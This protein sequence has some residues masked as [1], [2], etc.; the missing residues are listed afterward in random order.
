MA[1]PPV[2]YYL[3]I[4]GTE[5]QDAATFGA[6]LEG[7]G[8]KNLATT[9]LKPAKDDANR[10]FDPV[11]TELPIPLVEAR[12]KKIAVVAPGGRDGKGLD[13]FWLGLGQ[14]RENGQV[15]DG[16]K[17]AANLSATFM[18][19]LILRPAIHTHELQPDVLYR[20]LADEQLPYPSPHAPAARILYV[21]SH[22]YQ[23]G[24]MIGERLRDPAEPDVKDYDPP[25][26][27]G[28]VQV[29]DHGQGFHGPEWIVLAQCSTLNSTIWSL[30]ARVLAAS[31]PGVRGILAYEEASPKSDPAIRIAE[32]FFGYL[33]RGTPFLDAWAEANR[34]MKWSALV[35][36]EARR[37]TLAN[38]SRWQQL[39]DVSTSK[40]KASYHGYGPAL[41]AAGEPVYDTLPPFW[42]RLERQSGPGVPFQEVVPERYTDAT[43]RF[44]EGANY[45]WTVHGRDIGTIREARITVVHLRDSLRENQPPWNKLFREYLPVRGVNVEGFGTTTVV[46]RPDSTVNLPSI[47]WQC[48]A[49]RGD[50]AGLE[51]HSFLWFRVA[52]RTDGG[53]L[54]HDF[55]SLGLY[56]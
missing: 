38:I 22:G 31:S 42:L 39:S 1:G 30:W 52:I 47:E 56:Y 2:L 24:V 4:D 37:D 3:A 18:R 44:S 23:S 17:L 40:T 10:L 32:R 16:R 6:L 11:H 49:N 53:P 7:R 54:Q 5:S 9:Y 34:G 20:H 27:F 26:Y 35:H 12:G 21:S 48:R 19:Q 28:P 8:W 46:L 51:P 45:R 43:A 14:V 50:H 55:K 25:P 41:A 15:V 29:A 13:P 33:D 36:K